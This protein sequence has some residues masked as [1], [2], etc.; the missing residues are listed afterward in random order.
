MI[1]NDHFDAYLLSE[2]SLFVQK[3][4]IM[5][6]TCGK[7]ILLNCLKPILN[8]AF[9]AGFKSIEVRFRI[10]LWDNFS[11]SLFLSFFAASRMFTIRTKIFFFHRYNLILI[12]HSTKRMSSWIESFLDIHN[13]L[14]VW[15]RIVGIS[16]HSIIIIITIVMMIIEVIG[17]DRKSA[18]LKYWFDRF[19]TILSLVTWMRLTMVLDYSSFDFLFSSL[20]FSIRKT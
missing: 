12:I 10:D 2:S 6:K 16:F 15:I 3:S 14:A 7:T 18:T 11:I 5:I 4:S 1:H 13:C 9:N 19:E 20:H 8:L 17:C